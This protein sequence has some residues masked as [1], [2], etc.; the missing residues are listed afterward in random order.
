MC[1]SFNASRSLEKNTL[2]KSFDETTPFV[3]DVQIHFFFIFIFWQKIG[4][5]IV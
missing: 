3:D 1:V 4:H 2:I 5:L